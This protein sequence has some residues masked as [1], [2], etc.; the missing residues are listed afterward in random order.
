MAYK[1]S[2]GETVCVPFGGDRAGSAR[3]LTAINDQMA[4]NH[5]R[6]QPQPRVPGQQRQSRQAI[7]GSDAVQALPWPNPV[8]AVRRGL[9][10]PGGRGRLWPGR[11]VWGG[12][13]V[14]VVPAGRHVSVTAPAIEAAQMRF[15]DRGTGN[16]GNVQKN[17]GDNDG[18]CS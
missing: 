12:S 2:P 3:A 6:I 18:R 8:Q 10:G 9:Q 16:P 5:D 17:K 4:R 1:P 11:R 15:D 13:V 7:T 14:A